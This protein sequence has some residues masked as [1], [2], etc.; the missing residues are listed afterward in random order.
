MVDIDIKI[1]ECVQLLEKQIESFNEVA[2]SLDMSEDFK[3]GVIFGFRE[4]QKAI[5]GFNDEL[6]GKL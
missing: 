6:I 3:I 2:P 5:E 1:I 4:S